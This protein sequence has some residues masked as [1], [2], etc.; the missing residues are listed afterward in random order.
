[1]KW[2]LGP[3]RR[4]ALSLRLPAPTLP[5]AIPLQVTALVSVLLLAVPALVLL[6]MP[7]PRAEGLGRLLPHAGLLQSFPAAPERQPPPL[8]QQRLDAPTAR[9]LWRQ[10]RQLWWQFWSHDQAGGAYLVMP[11]PR[12][13]RLGSLSTPPHS[14]QIDGLLVVSSGPLARQFLQ[15]QL[16]QASRRQQGLQLR[17]LQLL[18]SQPGAYWSRQGLEAM[19]GPMAPLLHSLQEGCVALELAP[20]DLLFGGEAASAVASRSLAPLPPPPPLPAAA[21]LPPPIGEGLLLRLSGR[22]LEALLAGLL[23][24]APVRE[25]V[26]S[27]YGLGEDQLALLLNTPFELRLRP[28]LAGPFQAGLELV[29]P[30]QGDPAAWTAILEALSQR[31][32]ARALVDTPALA[33]QPEQPESPAPAAA[34]LPAVTWRDAQGREVGGWRWLA[35]AGRPLQLLL[36]L[37][38]EPAAITSGEDDPTAAGAGAAGAGGRRPLLRLQARPRALA[39]LN[40]LPGQLPL[41]LLQSRQLLL[42]ADD[43]PPA[44]E[45]PA[46][47]AGISRLLGRLQLG[48]PLP[49]QPGTQPPAVAS[50]P[51]PPPP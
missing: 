21:D 4:P 33:E 26:Q 29:L 34:G 18:Q 28:R 3:L 44:E 15:E 39:A 48:K 13:V 6:R 12:Q 19:G 23:D 38:P 5:R 47:G 10:Q 51:E 1:M 30:V 40:L 43:G 17:C 7:R 49:I 22:S 16:V 41:P 8:W 11:L 27:V 20:G 36:F 31:L 45:Q 35:A 14:L 9:L 37:G 42:L 32:R 50:P 2:S 24:R 46:G 25:A